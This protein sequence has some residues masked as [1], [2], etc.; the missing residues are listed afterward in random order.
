MIGHRAL[1]M[2][3]PSGAALIALCLS[4]GSGSAQALV[5][6][7]SNYA[8]NVL[9]AARALEQISHQ[10][11]SLQNQAQMLVNQT[12]N[13]TNLPYSSQQSIGQS[14]TQTQQLLSEAQHLAYNIDQIDRAFQRLY[15]N[16]YSASTS[17]QQLTGDAKE[18]W[19]NSQAAFQDSLRVQAGVVQS[20][21]TTRNETD[22]LVSA[23]QSAVGALQAA[24]AGNQL[25]ALQIKQLA[26][27]TALIVAQARAENLAGARNTANQEQARAQISR[28]LSSGQGY[29]AQPVQLFR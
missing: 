29:Q 19:Q 25:T 12:R 7:P 2:L 1:R 21:A 23:S 18:R 13:L 4:S 9:Q 24:Q 5:Y 16:A 20:L 3:R 11:T 22:A 10:I 17:S 27:L 28:F 26:D 6:D 14:F 8:Q 15:P